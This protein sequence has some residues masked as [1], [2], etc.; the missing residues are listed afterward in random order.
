M[1]MVIICIYEYRS[2]IMLLFLLSLIDA[3][4]V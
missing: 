4:V 2:C 3:Q 1:L